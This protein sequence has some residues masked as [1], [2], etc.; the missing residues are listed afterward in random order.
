MTILQSVDRKRCA[1]CERWSGPRQVGAT[2]DT[3]AIAS[4]QETGLCNGGPWHG[5][6]RRAR[7]ACGRWT[8]W[9]ALMQTPDAT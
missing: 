5:S 3:V 4:E 2:A 9:P 7:A 8:C 1:S 6:E